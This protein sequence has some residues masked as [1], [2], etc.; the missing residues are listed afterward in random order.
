MADA[1]SCCLGH[2]HRDHEAQLGRIDCNLMGRQHRGAQLAKQQ[3]GGDKQTAL[4]QNRHPNGQADAEQL[5]DCGQAW[6]LEM[7]KQ[8]QV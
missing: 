8:A 5:L 6:P 7:A 3:R 4:H 1:N 2:G